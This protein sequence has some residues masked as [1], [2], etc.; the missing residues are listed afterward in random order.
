LKRAVARVTEARALARV[1]KSELYPG[2]SASG[3]YS[4]N[5]LSENG[6]NTPQHNLEFDDFSGSFDLSYEL[7]VWGR[8]L[9][10]K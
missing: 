8:V 4:R 10:P 3:A 9:C 5:R 7:D 1:S 2:I 6:A